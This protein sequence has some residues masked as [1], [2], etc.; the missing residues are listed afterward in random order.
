[1]SKENIFDF[2][3]Y[4]FMDLGVGLTPNESLFQYYV[5]FSRAIKPSRL[6][7]VGNGTGRLTMSLLRNGFDVTAIDKSDK[8]RP[9]LERRYKCEG[10]LNSLVIEHSDILDYKTADKYDLVVAA[11]EF[12]RHFLT[13]DD[14]S[15]FIKKIESLLNKDGVLVADIRKQDLPEF[16]GIFNCP[17]FTYLI[18]QNGVKYIQC[19]SWTED[20]K[21]NVVWVYFKYEELDSMKNLVRSYV[22]VLKHGRFE[23]DQ[24]K[25]IAKNYGMNLHIESGIVPGFDILLFTKINN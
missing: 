1:M 24:I 11:D 15:S 6:L 18:E 10:L 4:E 13:I 9:F 21:N 14:L 20:K 5:D 17:L 19:S 3:N 8:G 2:Y 7:E 23:F 12:I 25:S 16:G 22:K